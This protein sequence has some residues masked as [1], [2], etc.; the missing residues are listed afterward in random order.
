MGGIIMALILSY[1]AY[2]LYKWSV[3]HSDKEASLAK[4]ED[5]L[6]AMDLAERVS[7]RV[8]ELN[9]RKEALSKTNGEK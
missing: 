9:K 6:E 5:E 7:Y 4:I 8:N 2:R 1:I 3:R